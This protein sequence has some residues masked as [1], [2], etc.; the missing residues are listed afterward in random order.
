MP[1]SAEM[2]PAPN[3]SI[4]PVGNAARDR[5]CHV[6]GHPLDRSNPSAVQPSIARVGYYGSAWGIVAA[7]HS[8]AGL[9][10]IGSQR[11]EKKIR[12]WDHTEQKY[13][14]Q[15]AKRRSSFQCDGESDVCEAAP[16]KGRGAAARA[17]DHGD[18]ARRDRYVNV[19]VTENRQDSTMKIPPA[20]RASRPGRWHLVIPQTAITR[21]VMHL[22]RPR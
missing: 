13:S 10:P 17:G 20:Y 4:M 1:N 16:K 15:C 21:I 22:K 11:R 9:T 3:I 14:A 2:S 12:H 5:R 7:G 18:S 19:D 6:R 8:F